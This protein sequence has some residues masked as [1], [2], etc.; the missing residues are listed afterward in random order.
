M[1]GGDGTLSEVA[2]VTRDTATVLG[3][4]PCGT[5]NQLAYYLGIPG[6]LDRAV[7]TAMGNSVRRLDVGAVGER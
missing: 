5:G 3:I 4:I 2:N 6:A 1:A 7:A